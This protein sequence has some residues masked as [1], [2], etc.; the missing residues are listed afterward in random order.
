MPTW[1]SAFLIAEVVARP[2]CDDDGAQDG[3]GP[4]AGV[5][6]ARIAE[7]ERAQILVR[8]DSKMSTAAEA[9]SDPCGRWRSA[10]RSRASV[11][12]LGDLADA[13]AAAVVNEAL[14]SKPISRSKRPGRAPVHVRR[15]LRDLG[16]APKARC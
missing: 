4:G 11:R 9:G 7:V 13:P 16:V 1:R 2:P 10:P 3:E 8:E 14:C 6:I 12:D 5:R 15:E